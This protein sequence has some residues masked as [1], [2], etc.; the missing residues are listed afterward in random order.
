M[1]TFYYHPLS[2]IARRVWIALLEKGLS[3]DAV[4]IN[5][6]GQQ[7]KPDFLK[8][9]PFHHVPVLV[10]GD[11]RILES[12]AI[13]DYLEAQYPSPSLLPPTP[14]TMTSVR[15]VQMVTI[16]ELTPKL[17]ALVMSRE[18]PEGDEG[19]WQQIQT[20]LGFLS[21]QLGNGA[22]FGGECLSLADVTA[23]TAFPF[24]TRLGVE[25]QG[26]PTL[27]AWYDRILARESWQKSQFD[28]EGFDTWKRWL[29]LQIKRRQRR[30]K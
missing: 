5:L 4:V 21:E 10:D 25:L 15:M 27:A 17:P 12:L 7:K 1:L 9:N 20:I 26:Y 24:M 11:L 22:Y 16:N 28:E 30:K 3:F 13:L 19:L 2:P 8:L 6:N 18:S 29:L 14:A 23:G